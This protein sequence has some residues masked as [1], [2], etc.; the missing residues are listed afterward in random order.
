MRTADRG[1]GRGDYE[2][3]KVVGRLHRTGKKGDLSSAHQT[4]QGLPNRRFPVPVA[5][6]PRSFLFFRNFSGSV[7]TR[8]EYVGLLKHLSYY[9]F[10]R[11]LTPHFLTYVRYPFPSP[12]LSRP[13][14]CV[15]VLLTGPEEENRGIP[16]RERKGEKKKTGDPPF[17]P[18]LFSPTCLPNS[19]QAGI[20]EGGRKGGKRT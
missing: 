19:S 1:R 12:F 10:A 9:S 7:S 14:R 16:R 13:P 6:R 8:A 17:S 5:N 2:K 11:F 15:I 18:S 3:R 20:K 4:P